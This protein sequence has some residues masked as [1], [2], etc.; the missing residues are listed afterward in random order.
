MEND[1]TEI[2]VTLLCASQVL[3]ETMDD[4]KDTSVYRY[5]LKR[6]ADRMEKE[7]TKHIDPIIGKAFPEDPDA[8]NAIMEGI[9]QVSKILAK[10]EPDKIAYLTQFL[11][12]YDNE[13][14]KNEEV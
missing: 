11:K 9:T 10:M 5:S 1:K 3:H 2:L 14:V 7:L 8:F 4:L 6:T 13:V 12:T